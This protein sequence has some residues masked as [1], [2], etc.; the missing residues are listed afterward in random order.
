MRIVHQGAEDVR[1]Q[2][3][4]CEAD[5]RGRSRGLRRRG[6]SLGL[7][8]LVVATLLTDLPGLWN[9]ALY[10]ERLVCLMREDHPEV[11]GSLDL[12]TSGLSSTAS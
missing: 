12:E 7:A 8:D 2:D 11:G 5:R 6:A 9:E 4:R 10:A 3:L 1:A